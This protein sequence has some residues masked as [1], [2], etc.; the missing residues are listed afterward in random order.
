MGKIFILIALFNRLE[1]KNHNKIRKIKRQLIIFSKET[2]NIRKK[3]GRKKN[4]KKKKF[5]PN[6]I[7]FKR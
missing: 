1:I 6:L 2:K 3:L 7:L 4:K 5:R